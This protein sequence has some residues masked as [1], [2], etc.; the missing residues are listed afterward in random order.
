[1]NELS[2]MAKKL[3]PEIKYSTVTLKIIQALEKDRFVFLTGKAGSGKSHNI[4]ALQKHYKSCV[5]TATTGIASINVSGETMHSFLCIDIL[6]NLT[7]L[8][9]S[10]LKN[11]FSERYRL[12]WETLLSL[13]LLIVD[14]VSM[15]NK[16]QLRMVLYRIKDFPNIK[17]LLVGD[18]PQLPP[19]TGRPLYA[20]KIFTET[21]TCVKL[22]RNHRQK[23]DMKLQ[24]VLHEV[25][26]SCPKADTLKYLKELET[27]VVTD[28]VKLRS[29]NSVVEEINNEE[30]SKL[31]TEP[32]VINR[33]IT[34]K[35]ASVDKY[36]LDGILNNIR[37]PESLLLK[38]GARVMVTRNSKKYGIYN[39]DLATVLDGSGPYKVILKLDRDNRIITLNK[40]RSQMPVTLGGKKVI[41]IEYEAFSLIL[42]YAITIHKSQGMTLAKVDIDCQG[43]FDR[44]MFY[45]ALS[46]AVNSE[47]IQLHNT[48]CLTFRK[49]L[50]LKS[51][52]YVK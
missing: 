32:F 23:D 15:M 33:T 22:R 27:N 37:E 20:S 6:E 42:A 40:S 36:V 16:E 11:R 7:D 30:I 4:R 47:G 25:R 29:K 31:N 48:D 28:A 21:F 34:F 44:H 12:M 2:A 38:I 52:W 10:D 9:K 46:R 19:V 49:N 18:F 51:K 50:K 3:A 43:I 1:M 13:E 41:G 17:V 5:V 35:H 24:K 8:K 39:G 14:E 26:N 45:T